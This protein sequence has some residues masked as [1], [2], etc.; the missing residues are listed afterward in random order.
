MKVTLAEFQKSLD[1]L[2]KH[3]PP[4]AERYS[5]YGAYDPYPTIP[6]ALLSAGHFASYALMTGMIDK[7]DVTEIRKPASLKISLEGDVRYRNDDGSVESFILAGDPANYDSR[8]DVRS[9]FILRPNSLCYVTLKPYFRMPDYI[10]AR[11]NLLIRDVYRGLLVGTGP[12]VDPG[13]NGRL[14]IPI[15]NLTTNEYKL[16]ADEGFVYFEFTKISWVNPVESPPRPSWFSAA[17]DTQPPF[18]AYKNN[19][20]GL[21]D[22]LD[23]ATG[24]GAA[25]NSI[26]SQI[27]LF[28]GH[29]NE[30]QKNLDS[31]KWQNR[32]WS[33][34][35]LL[36]AAGLV[37]SAWSVYVGAQSFTQSASQSTR[38]IQESIR[39]DIEE[40]RAKI[41]SQGRSGALELSIDNGRATAR[42]VRK[43][44][45]TFVPD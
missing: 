32:I 35:A 25:Q 40:L 20:E 41:E 21:D 30:S 17:L 22:Y 4:A 16:K 38:E 8:K 18:P 43:T 12:L 33:L 23:A 13:F 5:I 24:N 44:D 42:I 15:H 27:A 39:H 31:A 7:L 9:S 6:P 19:R 2:N 36:G 1:G 26:G 29:L 37:F 28:R 10:A 14:S 3:L 34:A 45:S 11:F